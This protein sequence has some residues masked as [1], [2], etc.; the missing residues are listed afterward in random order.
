MDESGFLLIPPV[1]RTWAPRGQTPVLRCA[2]RWTKISAISAVCVA[3]KRR[4]IAL[5]AG[6]LRDRNVR[7]PDVVRF[8]RLLLKRLRGPVFIVWDNI[9]Q[10][11]S[12]LVR[13]F[14][15]TAPRLKLHRFPGYAPELN[16]DEFIWSYLKRGVANTVPTDLRHLKRLIHTPLQRLRQ[17]QRLLW[18][19][20][21]ASELS[22]P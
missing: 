6:F 21:K 17:S 2:G 13:E 20:V 16:P 19:C 14:L 3:P 22:W 12:V 8:L 5:H 10:H 7:S 1:A 9:N 4:R 18:A 15:S 11:R